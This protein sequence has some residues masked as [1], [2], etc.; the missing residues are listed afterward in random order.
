MWWSYF[1]L[2]YLGSWYVYENSINSSF[3]DHDKT[4]IRALISILCISSC[5][6]SARSDGNF[7]RCAATRLPNVSK[8]LFFDLIFNIDTICSI[9][10]SK[11]SIFVFLLILC[12]CIVL[13]RLV[14][15]HLFVDLFMSFKLLVSSI[16]A[17]I[18]IICVPSIFSSVG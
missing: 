2:F 1:D 6:T 17:S 12:L 14:D 9:A 10:L 4:L 15:W 8:L 16:H 11:F 3:I 13:L 18:S 5:I 7:S